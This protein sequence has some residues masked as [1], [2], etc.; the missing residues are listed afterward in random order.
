MLFVKYCACAGRYQLLCLF[1]GLHDLCIVIFGHDLLGEN[2]E[3]G[4]G[5]RLPK[6][7]Q[8]ETLSL[9]DWELAHSFPLGVCVN[10][11]STMWVSNELST[12]L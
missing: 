2:I 3:E 4:L 10:V 1:N 9:Q 6:F 11:A 7:S 8:N 12:R 5:I